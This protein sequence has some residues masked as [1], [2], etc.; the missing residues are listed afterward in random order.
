MKDSLSDDKRKELVSWVKGL[1]SFEKD[2]VQQI[3]T[4][5]EG[6]IADQIL[7][8]QDPLLEH[9]LFTL[10]QYYGM[11]RRL[12]KSKHFVN[13]AIELGTRQKNKDILLRARSNL[14]IIN[15]EQGQYYEAIEEW[16]NMIASTDSPRLICSCY[17]NLARA[18]TISA[19]EEEAMKCCYR[20]IEMLQDIGDEEA[21]ANSYNSLGNLFRELH[22]TD[23]AL[24]YFEKS[25]TIYEK[26]DNKQRLAMIYNNLC[27][28]YID[29]GDY[30][31]ALTIG[32]DALDYVL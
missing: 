8:D 5:F 31:N 29:S 21:L 28:V 13:L 1:F 18:F 10:A 12:D 11:S 2:Q 6:L 24:D 26:I 15:F 23:K 4:E 3:C 22:K 25:R 30:D 19:K 14:A 20:A 16:E 17:Q 27:L 9:I 7:E 32:T